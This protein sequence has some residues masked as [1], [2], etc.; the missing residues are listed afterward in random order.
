[1][2]DPI[3]ELFQGVLGVSGLGEAA[4]QAIRDAERA[5]DENTRKARAARIAAALTAYRAAHGIFPR[6]QRPANFP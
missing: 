1:M 6:S 4:V 3:L 2:N 5:R